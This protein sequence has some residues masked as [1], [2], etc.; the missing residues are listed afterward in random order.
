MD[1]NSISSARQLHEEFQLTQKKEAQKQKEVFN[2]LIK[3][4]QLNSTL[5]ANEIQKVLNKFQTEN[6]YESEKLYKKNRNLQIR[7][8]FLT[9]IGCTFGSWL[10]TI[11]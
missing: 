5:T 11:L 10:I 8:A 6:R 1:L 4:A 7:L 9:I 3:G 2:N